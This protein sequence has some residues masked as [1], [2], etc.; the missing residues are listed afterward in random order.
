MRS[1]RVPAIAAVAGLL[2]AGGLSAGWRLEDRTGVATSDDLSLDRWLPTVA[3]AG[4][5]GSV[6]YCVA[7]TATG[8]SSGLAEQTVVVT[9]VGDRPA[10]VHLTAVPSEGEARSTD[11]ELAPRTRVDTPVA[12]LV[13]APFAAALVEVTGGQ[14]AVG[15][16]LRG[17][18]GA[19][20]GPCASN[21]ATSWFFPAGTTRAASREV[22]VA[23]NPF[24][25]EAVLDIAFSTDDGRRTPEAFQGRIVPAGR[26]AVLEVSD[27]VTV[28]DIV[29]TDVRVRSGRVAVERLAVFDP[30]AGASVRTEAS[31]AG[32]TTTTRAGGRPGSTTST[33]A[34]RA[35]G[36]RITTPDDVD[37]HAYSAAGTSVDLGSP[38]AAPMWVFPSSPGRDADVREEYL[39]YNPGKEA[40]QAVIGVTLEAEPGADPPPTVEPFTVT[41]RPEQYA[42]VSLDNDDRVPVGQRHTDIVFTT[43][44][45]PVIAERFVRRRAGANVPGLDLLIGSPLAATSWVVPAAS[46]EGAS[47][48]AI[49]VV[50]PD[51]TRSV[52]VRVSV[53]GGGAVRDVGGAATLDVPA[54]SSRTVDIALVDTEHPLGAIVQ[55]DGPVVVGQEVTLGRPLSQASSL[56]VPLA[57]SLSRLIAPDLTRN[58]LVGG[59]IGSIPAGTVFTVPPGSDQ[60]LP[61]GDDHDNPDGPLVGFG[62]TPPGSVP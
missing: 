12:D 31:G 51:A 17:R 10:R 13:K 23:Y 24:P 55:A 26:L 18:L 35:T 46:V 3:G 58:V 8:A 21:P 37:A 41:V 61:S 43:N 29:A 22:L 44:G 50:N 14:V 7:G 15:H 39:L 53:V 47:S 2:V 1:V 40:A 28:R 33:T 30:D 32:T 52:R 5:G 60:V 11:F 38:V 62:S 20:Q 59:D 19:S 49:T 27:V 6:W 57:G 45:V 42:R 54:G 16:L 25:D 56:A 48:S 4:A 36:T 34:P 9:N